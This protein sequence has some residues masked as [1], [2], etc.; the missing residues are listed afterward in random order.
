MLSGVNRLGGV[1]AGDRLPPTPMEVDGPCH[2]IERH[3]QQQKHPHTNSGRHRRG[4]LASNREAW[5]QEDTVRL[6][7][8]REH[9][10][11][12]GKH[13]SLH[14]HRHERCSRRNRENQIDLT[15]VELPRI[16]LAHDQ[17][18][19]DGEHPGGSSLLGEQP[20]AQRD[21]RDYQGDRNKEPRRLR[22]WKRQ[23]AQ[24][25]REHCECRKVLEL[26]VSVVGA[27][28]GL[29]GIRSNCGSP[30]DLEIAHVLG[31][32]QGV[33]PEGCRQKQGGSE[34]TTPV[35]RVSATVGEL[36][37]LRGRRGAAAG[38]SSIGRRT[39]RIP[40]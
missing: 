29:S 25:H 17:D 3:R 26:V 13:L 21:E 30:P 28:Q 11:R 33:G 16:E 14:F 36:L 8:D 34:K 37:R 39:R 2:P 12:G 4:P 40:S 23:D 6:D 20:N 1:V 27:K 22:D 9:Q 18:H 7:G 5:K 15:Q 32:A 38:A 19:H 35:H 10:Q 31:D 24:R